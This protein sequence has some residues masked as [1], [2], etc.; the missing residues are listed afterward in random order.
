MRYSKYIIGSVLILVIWLISKSLLSSNQAQIPIESTEYFNERVEKELKE[1]LKEIKQP[2]IAA[3]NSALSN[4]P[5]ILPIPEKLDFCGE[6]VP[7]DD[8]DVLE[9]FEKELYIT[10]H[11]YYQVVFYLKRGPRIFPELEEYLKQEGAPLDLIYL[12]VIESDLIPNIRS[13]KGALGLWQ[14]MPGTAKNYRLRVDKY[15]DER[16]HTE[17]ATRAAAKYLKSAYD[18]FG[19]WTL[20]AAAYNMGFSRTQSTIKDQKSDDYYKL[21]LNAETSRYV[22]RI[23]A[24]K[25]IIE[26]PQLYGYYLPQSEMYKKDDVKKITI[27]N[28][29]M[30][31]PEWVKQYDITYYDLKRYNPWIINKRL[32]RGKFTIDI[33]A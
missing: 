28:G 24:A 30:D 26:N 21:F 17:K 19:S 16:M 9:R 22:F 25:V 20:A 4:I 1:R 7:L 32:P 13:P 11:R 29:I 23:L 27:Q 5:L 12:S 14:F 33:P 3:Q 2:E 18:K 31:L 8:P 10:A 6:P 15:I